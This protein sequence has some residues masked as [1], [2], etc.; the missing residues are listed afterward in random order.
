MG[1]VLSVNHDAL[2]TWITY[3]GYF[4]LS[5]GMLL[6]LFVPHTR[7]ALLGKL[8]KKSHQK[9]AVLLL[10]ATL[11]G[12]N[13]SAQQHNH[14]MEPTEIPAE[15]AAEFGALLVQDQDGRLKPLNTLSNEMLRKVSRKA[16]LK[17]KCR[18]GFDGNAT[19]TGKMAVAKK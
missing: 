8:L 12:S 16:L 1:T 10:M 5:L 15:M 4:L 3:L 2:G 18:S 7:F 13:L 14:S 11:A 6:A 19:G 17:L 9:T